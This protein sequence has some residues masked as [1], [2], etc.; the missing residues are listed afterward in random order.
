[1]RVYYNV[2]YYQ[3]IYNQEAG[4][5]VLT[6]IGNTKIN[7][8]CTSSELPLARKAYLNAPVNCKMADKIIFTKIKEGDIR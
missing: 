4:E 7:N 6:W 8:D 5:R 1:M 3:Y 2:D